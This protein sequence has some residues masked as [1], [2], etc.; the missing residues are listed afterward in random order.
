MILFPAI[1]LK[2]G[3]CVRLLRGD[4]A[5]ATVFGDDPAAQAASFQAAGC[6]WLHLVDLDGAFAGQPVNAA[7]EF[8]RIKNAVT[9]AASLVSAQR[10]KTSTGVRKIPPPVPVRPEIRPITPPM[11]RARVKGGVRIDTVSLAVKTSRTAESNST[12]PRIV[13]K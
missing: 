13:F 11:N 2:D 12:I 6:A 5:A 7:A 10:Q 9:A 4:M 3:Q 8:S 1:D